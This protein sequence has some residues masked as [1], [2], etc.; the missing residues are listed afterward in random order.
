M[1]YIAPEYPPNLRILSACCAVNRIR[2]SMSAMLA[3]SCASCACRCEIWRALWLE[4][5]DEEEAVGKAERRGLA[6]EECGRGAWDIVG[7]EGGFEMVV[8]GGIEVWNGVG[9]VRLEIGRSSI[10]VMGLEVGKSSMGF[11]G[12]KG[13]R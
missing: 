2:L 12:N 7:V 6:A 11:E 8:V 4:E 13:A 10:N 3:V 5:E 9:L 1:T